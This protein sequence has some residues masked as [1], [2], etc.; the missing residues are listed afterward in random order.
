MNLFITIDHLLFFC[1]DFPFR[2]TYTNTRTIV[3][4]DNGIAIPMMIKSVQPKI[5]QIS[6]LVYLR[7]QQPQN[8]SHSKLCYVQ[9]KIVDSNQM[10]F[11][12]KLILMFFMGFNF[13][14][15]IVFRIIEIT[16]LVFLDQY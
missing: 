9:I 10:N 2:Q 13:W 15:N 16:H 7:K 12:S 6:T 8:M 3:A 14:D 5:S 1:L 4:N 11:K